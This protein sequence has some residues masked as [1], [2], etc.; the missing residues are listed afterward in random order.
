MNP[1]N[2]INFFKKPTGAFI[3]FCLV[4]A[5]AFFAVKRFLPGA[6]RPKP[7]T[8]STKAVAAEARSETRSCPE[9]RRPRFDAHS[10]G[11]HRARWQ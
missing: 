6:T 3:L 4:L 5:V 8:F 1:R 2:V 7:L 10:G 11:L 9:I